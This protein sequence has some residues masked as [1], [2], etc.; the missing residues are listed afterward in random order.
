SRASV[1]GPPSGI[2]KVDGWRPFKKPLRGRLLDGHEECGDDT[3]GNAKE[4]APR[5]GGDALSNPP[6]CGKWVGRHHHAPASW[7]FQGRNEKEARSR[8]AA[9]PPAQ[10]AARC[11]ADIYRYADS[12]RTD[13]FP[14]GQMGELQVCDRRG[15]G[16]FNGAAVPSRPFPQAPF[17]V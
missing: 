10:V 11:A 1:G 17:S 14:S 16:S 4:R 2:C 6:G 12:R 9:P 15:L 8:M 5:V 13:L 7:L 3:A